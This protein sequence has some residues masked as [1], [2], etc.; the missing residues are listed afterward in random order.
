M[1]PY[2]RMNLIVGFGLVIFAA[3]MGSFLAWS[4]A[5]YIQHAPELLDS[6]QYIL[7]RSA[8]GHTSLFGILHVLFGLSLTYSALEA[9]VKKLQSLGLFSG[10]LSM[11]VLMT[12]RSVLTEPSSI[13]LL[14]FLVGLLLSLAALS[15]V[16]HLY[17]IA[18]SSR[19][20][21]APG[22]RRK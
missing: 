13:D 6:W 4:S 18:S 16:S 2:V 14:G 19:E 1:E 10:S 20:L 21:L 12:I 7:L 15:L 8:H 17:G 5:D 11:A 9:R 3:F 22:E